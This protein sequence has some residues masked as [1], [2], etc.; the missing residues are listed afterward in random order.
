MFVLFSS[1]FFVSSLLLLAIF[2]LS[3]FCL[4]A[5]PA[6]LERNSPSRNWFQPSLTPL[7]Y[8]VLF[9]FV[10]SF[11]SAT[12]SVIL[13]FRH[14]PSYLCNGIVIVFWYLWY[15]RGNIGERLTGIFFFLCLN[16]FSL[17]RKV[18]FFCN[19]QKYVPLLIDALSR[20]PSSK[21]FFTIKHSVRIFIR[22]PEK[23]L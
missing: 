23:K 10:D 15:N 9:A 21:K 16:S 14:E 4:F 17:F 20:T 5:G 18:R 1:L 13:L 12:S 6:S 7:Y 2:F 8:V 3:W 19:F 22:I 11:K